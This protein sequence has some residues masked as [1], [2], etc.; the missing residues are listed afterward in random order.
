MKSVFILVNSKKDGK[1]EFVEMPNIPKYGQR[2]ED[3]GRFKRS[4]L[5]ST[6]NLKGTFKAIR[7]HLAANTVGETKDKVLAQQLINIIFCKIYDER[8]TASD[9]M[10]AFRAGF[11]D[12]PELVKKRILDLF[13]DVK[14]S[15]RALWIRMTI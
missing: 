15:T 9:D 14:I 7:N 11:D 8:H 6:H 13:V 3:I 1:V 10:V 5:Q 2:V 4:E 12:E